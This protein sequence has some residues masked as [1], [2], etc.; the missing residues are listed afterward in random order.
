MKHV[1]MLTGL[2][3]LL[4]SFMSC[5]STSISLEDPSKYP[6]LKITDITVG[7]GALPAF[8]NTVI[9]HY[10]GTFTN[11]VKFDSSKDRGVPFSFQIGVG[12]VI[13]GWDLGVSTMRI[14]GK[15]KL[16]IPPELGYGNKTQGPIPAN[17]TLVFEVEL[18]GIQ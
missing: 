12:E 5:D 15:R 11:G 18:L 9:V 13:K 17:S 3:G 2:C 14:G 6:N 4:F 8:G 7:T 16:I 10:T 1:L